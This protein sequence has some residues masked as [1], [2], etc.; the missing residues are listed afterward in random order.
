VGAVKQAVKKTERTCLS[1]NGDGDENLEMRCQCR[2]FVNFLFNRPRWPGRDT[3]ISIPKEQTVQSLHAKTRKILACWLPQWRPRRPPVE[4]A[5]CSKV[6]YLCELPRGSAR[7]CRVAPIHFQPSNQQPCLK[8]P[9][10]FYPSCLMGAIPVICQG[11]QHAPVVWP[12][13]TVSCLLWHSG[14]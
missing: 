14:F 9:C 10:M 12:L 7:F 3:Y 6:I 1:S 13:F 4:E 2:T 5:M 8:P 11:A